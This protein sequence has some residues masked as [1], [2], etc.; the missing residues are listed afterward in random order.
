MDRAQ[1]RLF[2]ETD[3]LRLGFHD[4]D[5]EPYQVVMAIPA[6]DLR[7]WDL[8]DEDDAELRASQILEEEHYRLFDL[9]RGPIYRFCLIRIS[10]KRWIWYWCSHH[11]VLDGVGVGNA[12]ARLVALYD[13]PECEGETDTRFRSFI[14]EDE[15]YRESERWVKDRTFWLEY[16]DNCSEPVSFSSKQHGPINLA[17]SSITT[18]ILSA[19]DA[20]SIKGFCKDNNLTPYSFFAAA[21]VLYIHRLTGAD[22]ICIGCPTSFRPRKYRTMVGMSSNVIPLRIQVGSED[23]FLDL[24]RKVSIAVRGALRHSRYPLSDIV[25]DRR[26]ITSQEP[27]LIDV[28]YQ[29]IQGYASFGDAS[30]S[31][32]IP[33]SEPV[34]DLS[35]FVFERAGDET[36]ELRLSFNPER[37]DRAD[38]E[39]H[40]HR[41]KGLL[42]KLATVN[43]APIQSLPILREDEQQQVIMSS[44]GPVVEHDASLLTL[45]CLFD[46]QSGKTPDAVALIYEDQHLSYGDLASR[47]NQLARYLIERGVGPDAVVGVLMDRSLDTVITLLGIIKSGAAYLPLD[48][49]YPVQRLGLMVAGV[50]PSFIMTT[51]SIEGAL[52]PGLLSY[53]EE[54]A[55]ALSPVSSL[56]PVGVLPERLLVDDAGFRDIVSGYDDGVIAASELW[57]LGVSFQSACPLSD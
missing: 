33:N 31:V 42:V 29:T 27:F 20:S 5:G 35:F 8:R 50:G 46:A 52:G 4:I 16:L 41:F 56:S 11:L 7:I 23:C 45:P 39:A 12:L 54:H 15:A 57:R 37:Y 32:F 40:L 19:P 13:D 36:P 48:P 38:V 9:E 49:E 34:N 44:S 30:G 47:S 21:M 26:S 55:A 10:E 17:V 24:A 28:N 18:D 53:W 51:G 2:E 25:N 3:V 6:S 43:N 14:S 1:K 22:D